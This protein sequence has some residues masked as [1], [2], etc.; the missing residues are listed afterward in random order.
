[1]LRPHLNHAPVRPLT[2]A[3]CL[4]LGVALV[5][6]SAESA[7]L[8]IPMRLPTFSA[9]ARPAPAVPRGGVYLTVVPR[10]GTASAAGSGVATPS[11]ALDMLRDIDTASP[12]RV[13]AMQASERTQADATT[14]RRRAWLDFCQPKLSPPD[15]WGVEHWIYAHEGCEFGRT[16]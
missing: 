9:P 3:I 14:T 15:R 5:P 13:S 2:A 6:T 8:R 1:M 4:A 16:E 7:R 12:P 10:P 11:P